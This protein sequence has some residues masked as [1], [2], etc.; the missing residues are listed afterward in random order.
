MRAS[1]CHWAALLHL[2]LLLL[3]LLPSCGHR[4]RIASAPFHFYKQRWKGEAGNQALT[5]TCFG[6]TRILPN[7]TTLARVGGILVWLD[8]RR[9]ELWR[10]PPPSPLPP[11]HV[12]TS[13][14]V[15]GIDIVKKQEGHAAIQAIP[16]ISRLA[17]GSRW[18]DAGI[19]PSSNNTAACAGILRAMPISD[20][21][22]LCKVTQECHFILHGSSGGGAACVLVAACLHKGEKRQDDGTAGGT[23]LPPCDGTGLLL[24]AFLP[25]HRVP[26]ALH[27]KVAVFDPM[28][29]RTVLTNAQ[30]ATSA[31]PGR[32]DIFVA[33]L[34]LCAEHDDEHDGRIDHLRV[35]ECAANLR[36][37]Y[38]EARQD[39]GH[40]P[41]VPPH[42]DRAGKDPDVVRM[43][44][45]GHGFTVVQLSCHSSGSALLDNIVRALFPLLKVTGGHLTEQTSGPWLDR[46]DDHPRRNS[47]LIFSHVRHPLDTIVSYRNRVR[48]NSR[49]VRERRE[50]IVPGEDGTCGT[51]KEWGNT[52]DVAYALMMH[53]SKRDVMVEQ[54]RVGMERRPK[55]VVFR[56]E[57]WA[58]VR[59]GSYAAA[60]AATAVTD[61]ADGGARL[62]AESGNNLYNEGTFSSLRRQ[63]SAADHDYIYDKLERIMNVTIP[64]RIRRQLRRHF[65]SAVVKRR[66]VESERRRFDRVD[67]RRKR[68]IEVQKA[69]K[70]HNIRAAAQEGARADAREDAGEDVG[71][72][73]AVPAKNV[74]SC[75]WEQHSNLPFALECASGVLC[76]LR[77]N[78]PA[79][80]TCCGHGNGGRLHCPPHKPIMCAAK[81]C[82]TAGVPAY[83]C[84]E[85]C[86][87]PQLG[88][89][90]PCESEE[91]MC[92]L[93]AVCSILAQ[94]MLPTPQRMANLD[95]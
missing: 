73:A 83:C 62:G 56:F 12:R 81:S 91:G 16:V 58:G 67:K 31:A 2:V 48:Q 85:N 9:R 47:M 8:S 35:I 27:Q 87:T 26:A 22:H 78:N 10:V 92:T 14:Q 49:R 30:T 52:D 28:R 7:S 38:L 46:V 74:R 15:C 65:S 29:R 17:L 5:V 32:V 95:E 19:L 11:G 36:R 55:H 66:L 89:P 23:P 70:A 93:T 75:L 64:E 71:R 45:A 13:V 86:D 84:E 59:Q 34:L 82:G 25:P 44:G 18:R 60:A 57:D 20:C 54:L 77:T 24:P 37:A 79:A 94:N 3:L 6:C 33:A 53:N 1:S 21:R 4:P 72:V 39:D 90:R 69:S 50:S 61:A 80:W 88:G 63:S 51:D 68:W 42:L 43:L 41:P 76:D 40:D